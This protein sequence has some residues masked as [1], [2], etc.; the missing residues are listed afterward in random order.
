MTPN[1]VSVYS[2]GNC[3]YITI[4]VRN[5]LLYRLLLLLC[6]LLLLLV[7]ATAVYYRA[8]LPILIIAV[9]GMML[10]KYTLWSLFGREIIK[11]N[12]KAFAFHYEYGFFKTRMVTFVVGRVLSCKGMP[13]RSGKKLRQQYLEF[14]S[15][16]GN[17]FP[18]VV[19]QAS[20][21]VTEKDT[22][23]IQ[24]L[25]DKIYVS[26]LAE[27]KVFSVVHLN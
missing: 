17:D 12:T 19:Y 18:Y 11:F 26:K 14:E 22:R 6:N 27:E 8:V 4:E 9:A 21:P 5:T 10:G 13:V 25:I 1:Y 23:K 2:D 3:I 15:L 16:D 24:Q 7:L 20:L